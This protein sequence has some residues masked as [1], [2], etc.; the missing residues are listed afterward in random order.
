M[1]GRTLR[2]KKMGGSASDPRHGPAWVKSGRGKGGNSAIKGESSG[3]GGSRG[4]RIEKQPNLGEEGKKKKE[5][6]KLQ[7]SGIGPS[8]RGTKQKGQ[9]E[10]KKTK[11]WHGPGVAPRG[12]LIPLR[13]KRKGQSV[14][15]YH[16]QKEKGERGVLRE[17]PVQGKLLKF[18]LL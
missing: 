15:V 4:K 13:S 7:K 8:K 17:D 10:R 14:L 2:G 3:R 1:S 18:V 11:C 16:T 12:T 5:D 9:V 6:R